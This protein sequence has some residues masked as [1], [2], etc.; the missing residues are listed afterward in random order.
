LDTVRRAYAHAI[1]ARYRFMSYG[2]SMLV[3]RPI[4][5]NAA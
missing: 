4:G 5:D 1:E 2:D 3:E